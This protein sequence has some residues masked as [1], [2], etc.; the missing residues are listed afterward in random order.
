MPLYRERVSRDFAGAVNMTAAELHDWLATAASKRVGWKGTDGRRRE[1]RGH[2][3]G[4]MIVAILDKQGRGLTEDDYLHMRK[5]VGFVC[6][7]IAQEPANVVTSRWRQSLM[8]W[9]HDPMKAS[10]Q[11]GKR[12]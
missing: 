3:S 8:N 4:R 5:V 10:V 2:E 6:R 12:A 11:A 1:S 7:H 9:G